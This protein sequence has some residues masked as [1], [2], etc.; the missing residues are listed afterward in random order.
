MPSVAVVVVFVGVLHIK[1]SDNDDDGDA[2]EHHHLNQ[3]GVVELP[4]KGKRGGRK[5]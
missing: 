3:V 4:R 1:R 5:H 2:M